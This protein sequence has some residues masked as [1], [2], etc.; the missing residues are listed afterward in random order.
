MLC[1]NE[2]HEQIKS[3]ANYGPLCKGIE[4]IKVTVSNQNCG[5]DRE[6]KKLCICNVLQYIK[7]SDVENLMLSLFHGLLYLLEKRIKIWGHLTNSISGGPNLT[8]PP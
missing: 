2:N 6:C 3:M 5:R 4:M 8:P 7:K 1:Q